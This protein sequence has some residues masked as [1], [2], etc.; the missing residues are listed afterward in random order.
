MCIVRL[1]FIPYR[2]SF[3]PWNVLIAF[4]ATIFSH[5]SLVSLPSPSTPAFVITIS[6]TSF[7]INFVSCH[8]CMYLFYTRQKILT[9]NFPPKA[10]LFF[11][12]S[13]NFLLRK[14][15]SKKMGFLSFKVS[16]VVIAIIRKIHFIII[17]VAIGNIYPAP[18]QRGPFLFFLRDCWS[19]AI[20]WNIYTLI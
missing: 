5:T 9:Q 17:S 1:V 14:Q 16:L 2:Q 20:A 18:S 19:E 13:N 12:E 15:L 6:W 10:I 7:V 11:S 8:K 4:A 3:S